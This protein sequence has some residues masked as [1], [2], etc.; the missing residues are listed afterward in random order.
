MANKAYK[1]EDDEDLEKLFSQLDRETAKLI[2]N[3][4]TPTKKTTTKKTPSKKTTV[5][6]ADTKKK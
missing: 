2:D 5:K 1:M 4:H 3:Q 6:K